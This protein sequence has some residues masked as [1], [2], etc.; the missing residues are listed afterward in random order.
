MFPI[1]SRVAT[2]QDL[3]TAENK[4]RQKNIRL[5]YGLKR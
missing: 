3:K 2:T 1:K 5:R 4:M